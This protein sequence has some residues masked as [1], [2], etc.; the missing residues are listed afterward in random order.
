MFS[1]MV[2]LPYALQKKSAANG[3]AIEHPPILRIFSFFIIFVLSAGTDELFPV[4]TGMIK[5]EYAGN[6]I[7]NAARAARVKNFVVVVKPHRY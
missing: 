4:P 3:I 7:E 1:G 6:L 5:S 2:I